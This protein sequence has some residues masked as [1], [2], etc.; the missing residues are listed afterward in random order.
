MSVILASC[1]HARLKREFLYSKESGRVFPPFLLFRRRPPFARVGRLFAS[2]H[3][4][5][6]KRSGHI[7]VSLGCYH[8]T[9]VQNGDTGSALNSPSAQSCRHAATKVI[10]QMQFE[11]VT[12]KCLLR[13]NLR[14]EFQSLWLWQSLTG[15]LH[16]KTAAANNHSQHVESKTSRR[17]HT[18]HTPHSCRH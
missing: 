5:L 4:V 16:K 14:H 15:Q 6:T 12:E 2:G 10:A 11:P 8:V 18:A 1:W 7:R 9:F 3:F 13:T 17:V